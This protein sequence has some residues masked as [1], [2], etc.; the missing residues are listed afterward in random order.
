EGPCQQAATGKPVLLV[1]DDLERIL[2]DPVPGGRHRVQA[3][4]APALAAV[5]R[6]FSL[7]QTESRLVLVSRYVFTLYQGGEDLADRLYALQLPPMDEAGARK[8]AL[9]RAQQTAAGVVDRKRTDELLARSI[10]LARGN[11]GL[12]H[13]LFDLVFAAPEAAARALEEM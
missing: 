7:S 4:H 13:K 1:I 3:V 5:L 6:A 11:P 10:E 2:H 9:R 8:Q 12:Q